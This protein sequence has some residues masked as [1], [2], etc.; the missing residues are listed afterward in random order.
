MDEKDGSSAH[1]QGVYLAKG[2]AEV[3]WF[4]PSPEP[5]LRLIA[6]TG[7]TNGAAVLDAG[8]GAS[9]LVDHLFDEG[10]R[11]SVLDIADSALDVARS[12]LGPRAAEVTWIVADITEWRPTGQFDLWHDR[13][14]FH[15]LTKPEQRA[16]YLAALKAG[17]APS[18]WLVMATFAPGG[19][20]RCS[21]L[22]VCRWS[23][24]ELAAELG[25]DFRLV[26][27][28]EERHLTPS[29]VQ[30]AFTWTLFRRAKRRA[31]A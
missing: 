16:R 21:G 4:Q 2:A 31:R 20:D 14:V 17:L 6:K 11:L 15:F 12:R 18:G 22:P 27:S 5:S 7:L 1:W 3:S 10:F 30:Q 24:P 25:D 8:G 23:A 28:V 26:E 13:A 9:T 19:P 29:G